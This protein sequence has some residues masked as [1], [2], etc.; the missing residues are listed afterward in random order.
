MYTTMPRSKIFLNKVYEVIPTEKLT[1]CR[2]NENTCC[3]DTWLSFFTIDMFNFLVKNLST[4][5][6]V[7]PQ[8]LICLISRM[9]VQGR[10]S[11]RPQQPASAWCLHT[12]YN[13]AVC[14]AVVG[15][16]C[17]KASPRLEDPLSHTFS[18]LP[19][20][21]TDLQDGVRVPQ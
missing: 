3:Q 2:R 20:L 9:L 12:A 6:I 11:H 19:P 16:H 14:G 8:F 5:E 18:F 4:W 17:G 13:V 15:R 10:L 7:S 1:T 21:P